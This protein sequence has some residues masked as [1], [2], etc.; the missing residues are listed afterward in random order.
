MT[1]CATANSEWH[2]SEAHSFI[3]KVW[4]EPAAPGEEHARWRGN[5]THVPGGERKSV[6]D[7]TE[8]GVLIAEH[9]KSLGVSL[10]MKW[11]I[12]LWLFRS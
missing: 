1:T 8:I 7:V 12:W 6:R 5:V 10:G 3:V 2:E 4:L 9:L 11:R